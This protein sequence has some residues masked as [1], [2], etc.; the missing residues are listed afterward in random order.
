[1]MNNDIIS[2]LEEVEQER[3]WYK[4]RVDIQEP[5]RKADLLRDLEYARN[6]Y[7]VKRSILPV[8]VMLGMYGLIVSIFVG[9]YRWLVH[10]SDELVHFNI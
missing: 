1:M 6:N 2:T 8:R 9:L 10:I 4:M 7:V 3:D 5:R